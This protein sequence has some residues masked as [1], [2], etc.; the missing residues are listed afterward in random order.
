M[1]NHS[2]G[3]PIPEISFFLFT[4]IIRIF[5]SFRPVEITNMRTLKAPVYK[6]FRLTHDRCSG[7]FKTI[8]QISGSVKIIGITKLRNGRIRHIIG[9]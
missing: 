8:I 3:S 9:D 7:M 6:I 5:I 2:P 4:F 1:F